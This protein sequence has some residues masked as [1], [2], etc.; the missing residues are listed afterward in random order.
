MANSTTIV[1]DCT[2]FVLAAYFIRRLIVARSSDRLPFPPGPPGLPIIKNL[3]DW[4]TS[5]EWEVLYQW[6][7]KY[8]TK[9]AG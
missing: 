9:Y 8:G 2:L 6:G 7:K 3:L 1:L 4:P 5:N